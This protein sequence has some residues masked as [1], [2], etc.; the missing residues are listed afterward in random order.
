MSESLISWW[1]TEQDNGQSEAFNKGFSHARGEWLTWLN[2]DDIMLPNS[3]KKVIA[4]IEKNEKVEWVTGGTFYFNDSGH[5]N[6]V[7]VLGSQL[8][9]IFR[10]PFWLQVSAP[11][12]FFKKELF[13][14]ASGID[15]SLHYVMDIDLWMRFGELGS[16]LF[17]VQDYIWGFRL[18]GESKTSSSVLTGFRQ[19]KFLSEKL[20]IRKKRNVTTLKV[21]W[22]NFL[23]RVVAILSFNW[24]RR[25][26]KVIRMR[27]VN[28]LKG[29]TKWEHYSGPEETPKAFMTR[30]LN[31]LFRHPAG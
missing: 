24:F 12:S 18:H 21:K 10:V 6:R 2:A 9:S 26:I 16:K 28:I 5:I 3:L 4:F 1:C 22:W 14:R 15:E 20:E 23:K 25:I 29:N 11:S 17:F 8:C 31:L 27:N 19:P 30:A 7:S 13:L